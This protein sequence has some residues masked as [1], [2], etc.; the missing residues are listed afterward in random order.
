MVSSSLQPVVTWM[1]S[2]RCSA[3]IEAVV[4][5]MGTTFHAAQ[6]AE[7]AGARGLTRRTASIHNM[8]T[9]THACMHARTAHACVRACM[10]GGGHVAP[11]PSHRPPARLTLALQLLDL[12]LAYALD[13]GELPLGRVREG[14]DCVYAALLELLDVSRRDAVRLQ[15]AGRRGAAGQGMGKRGTGVAELTALRPRARR[16]RARRERPAGRCC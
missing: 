5:P 1:I 14:L 11:P 13:G 6:C 12:G 9:A 2:P 7:T 15:A 3:T 10:D 8:L 16:A 4:K